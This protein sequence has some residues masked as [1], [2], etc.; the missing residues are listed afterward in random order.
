MGSLYTFLVN[1]PFI[2]TRVLILFTRIG[3][4]MCQSGSPRP[5]PW[6]WMFGMMMIRTHPS[7]TKDACFMKALASIQNTR[8]Q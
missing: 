5:P 8:H 3:P 6:Q 4:G 2:E 1:A 7:S